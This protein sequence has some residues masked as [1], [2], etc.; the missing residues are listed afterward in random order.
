MVNLQ[1][2]KYIV[3]KRKQ[4]RKRG[5]REKR[6]APNRYLALQETKQS[7]STKLTIRYIEERHQFS[8][9]LYHFPPFDSPF[10]QLK[11]P[12]ISTFP[13]TP[14]MPASPSFPSSGTPFSFPT[15]PPLPLHNSY[16]YCPPYPSIVVFVL[17]YL[18]V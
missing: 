6:N 16:I 5:G 9:S 2:L 7:N 1:E 8:L 15:K 18:F 12:Q 4:D 17:F 13:S 14:T 11:T 3:D 10:N